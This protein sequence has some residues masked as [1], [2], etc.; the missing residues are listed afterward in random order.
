MPEAKEQTVMVELGG[1]EVEMRQPTEAGLVV[2]A[3]VSRGLPKSM[4]ENVAEMPIEVR[5]KLVRNLGTIGKVVEAMVVQEDDKDWL[6]DVMISG[7]VTSEDVF[8][9]IG[10]VSEK[11][12]GQAAAKKAPPPV[13][14]RR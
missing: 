5:E 2:L 8:R 10:E 6:D 9:S 14:R 1:R 7:E 4:I 11:F 13:R 3:R 12:N